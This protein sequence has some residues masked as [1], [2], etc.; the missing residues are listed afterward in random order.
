MR[1]SKRLMT[2]AILILRSS[3]KLARSGAVFIALLGASCASS[4][5][6]PF[7]E[8]FS[9][10]AIV[11][12][13]HMSS[14]FNIMDFYVNDHSGGNVGREGGGGSLLCCVMLPWRWRPDLT[15]EVRWVVGDWSKEVPS[16]SAAGDYS[17]IAVDGIYLAKV[18]VEP[19]DE[20]GNLH[21]HFFSGGKVRVVTSNAG[22]W[23]PYHPIV[24]NDPSAIYKATQGKQIS[25]IYTDTEREEIYKKFQE[26]R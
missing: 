2:S 4:P 9:A 12:T 25:K 1:N 20:T 14:D 24:R 3:G 10:A 19:Y 23:S 11:G 16:K 5:V 18:P 7:K 8:K 15:V 13:H 17:S 21:V 6:A 22:S 26:E